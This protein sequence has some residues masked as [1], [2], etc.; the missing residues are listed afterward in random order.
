MGEI[1]GMGG[2]QDA[3]GVP[4]DNAANL[5][6]Y[7]AAREANSL[8]TS[9]TGDCDAGRNAS[10]LQGLESSLLKGK[11]IWLSKATHVSDESRPDTITLG[12]CSRRRA[13][14][15]S[16]RLCL[17][18]FAFVAF[19]SPIGGLYRDF[20]AGFVAAL[21]GGRPDMI[22]GAGV[23]AFVQSSNTL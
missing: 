5:L 18:A 17:A 23:G 8:R 13:L 22:S 4:P 12:F 11:V 3:R 21:F 2:T 16:G 6:N 20:K 19:V 7:H 15:R 9:P 14:S 1:E 10:P